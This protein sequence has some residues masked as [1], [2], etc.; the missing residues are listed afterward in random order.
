[1]RK[2]TMFVLCSL[3]FGCV[4]GLA[5]AAD[6]NSTLP[7]LASVKRALP[8]SNRPCDCETTGKCDCGETCKCLGCKTHGTGFDALKA[9]VT[10][11]VIGST[12]FTLT[13]PQQTTPVT[14]TIMQQQCFTDQFGFKRCQMVPVTVTES[15]PVAVAYRS[16][17]KCPCCGMI[18]TEGQAKQATQSKAASPAPYGAPVTYAAPVSYGDAVMVADDSSGAP[19]GFMTRGPVRRL[20][21][22]VFGRRG[23]GGGGCCGQ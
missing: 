8:A 16:G 18:M 9:L 23:A 14:R 13:E 7:P 17:D 21:G 20:F 15:V 22:K 3:A 4:S 10:A 19:G 1:M 12:D 5:Y 11:N 2:L 6:P